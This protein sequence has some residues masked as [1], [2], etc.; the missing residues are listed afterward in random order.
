MVGV[1][2]VGNY[3]GPSAA[4]KEYAQAVAA[5]CVDGQMP[6]D[7]PGH[8][9]VRK[10]LITHFDVAHR[11]DTQL[12]MPQWPRSGPPPPPYA[13]AYRSNQQWIDRPSASTDAIEFSLVGFPYHQAPKNP[14][15]CKPMPLP[16]HE[17]EKRQVR[18]RIPR[19]FLVSMDDWN[20][21]PQKLVRIKVTFPGFDP[22]TKAT[23]HCLSQPPAF[24]PTQ[25]LPVEFILRGGGAYEPPDDEAFDNSRDLFHSQEPQTAPYGFELYETGPPQ[26]RINTY[27]KLTAGRT[28]VIRCFLPF[29]GPNNLAVCSSQSRLESGNF[30]SYRIYSDQLKDAEAIDAG[31]RQ[32]IQKFQLAEALRPDE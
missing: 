13:D 26:A 2:A 1:M 6:D 24:R 14:E 3:R 5:S 21:G 7:W 22:L 4:A 29:A 15:C 23:E 27:R 11:E 28:L 25:C 17:G 10:S 30:V 9:E 12:E 16:D 8:D 31:I 20:G 19:N 18:Y 32:L